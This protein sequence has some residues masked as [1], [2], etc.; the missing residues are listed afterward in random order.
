MLHNLGF[1]MFKRSEPASSLFIELYEEEGEHFITLI[2]MF[3]HETI[4]MNRTITLS[5]FLIQ[6]EGTF[7]NFNNVFKKQSINKICQ[8]SI[9]ELLEIEEMSFVLTEAHPF[10]EK[11]T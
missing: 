7:L 6:I 9:T 5:E 11:L 4:K 1:D 8:L 10:L 2:Y 3:D